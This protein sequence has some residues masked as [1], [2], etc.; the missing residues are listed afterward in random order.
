M[1]GVVRCSKPQGFLLSSPTG[2]V[3]LARAG[4][5]VRCGPRGPSVEGVW[6][7]AAGPEVGKHKLGLGLGPRVWQAPSTDRDGSCSGFE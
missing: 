5:V 2:R 6:D 1:L 7:R 3:S 4:T